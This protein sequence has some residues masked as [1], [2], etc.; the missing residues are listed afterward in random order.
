MKVRDNLNSLERYQ[1]LNDK[2]RRFIIEDLEEIRQLLEDEEQGIQK[3]L[4]PN[5][6]IISATKDT[7]LKYQFDLLI[8]LYSAGEKIEIVREQ[9]EQTLISLQGVWKAENGYIEMVMMLSIGIMLEVEQE[10]FNILVE[11]VRKDNP[12]DYL[13]DL[14]INYKDTSW[15]GQSTKFMWN[16]PYKS[17]EEIVELSKTDKEKA[18]LRVLKYL[19]EWYKS[20]ENKTHNSKFNIHT[21][22]WC[23]ESGAL[24]KILGLDDNSLK[25]QQYYPYD[26]VRFND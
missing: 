1:E 23:W 25:G 11:C 16:N 10:K 2:K 14:L 8:G 6:E 17:T 20:V 12:K 15:N 9:Y 7:I 5:L 4:K 19:K 18:T 3:K 22:Y 26:M 13:I 24:V 21:G